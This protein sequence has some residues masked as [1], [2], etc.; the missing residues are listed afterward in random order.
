MASNEVQSI[1]WFDGSPRTLAAATYW[2][3]LSPTIHGFRGNGLNS[4]IPFINGLDY[5][6]A[7]AATPTTIGGKV[8]TDLT[9]HEGFRFA[10]EVHRVLIFSANLPDAIRGLLLDYLRT[11][12]RLEPY[13][14]QV[15]FDGSSLEA[16][17]NS[18][19]N[20]VLTGWSDGDY[21]YSYPYYVANARPSWKCLNH[22]I[23]SETVTNL[24]DHAA[25]AIDPYFDPALGENIVVLGAPT[26][27]LLFGVDLETVEEIYMDYV[28]QRQDVG[29]KVLGQA[30]PDRID[31]DADQQADV[32]TFN[33]RL[34]AGMYGVDKVGPLP[35]G[36]SG[37]SWWEAS[38]TKA[39]ADRT[40]L[41]RL[42]FQD[43]AAAT[44]KALDS[45]FGYPQHLKHRLL[46][47]R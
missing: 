45:F 10:G 6:P 26:N 13:E 9:F 24:A 35:I 37:K 30:I 44:L 38:P 33:Q 1:H 39:D 3:R 23:S 2:P 31:F 19:E 4:V 11:K 34:I 28:A 12:Y 36:L 42:G 27:D 18:V 32:D 14:A 22:G 43:W 16:G 29:F 15:I 8:G 41:S 17:Y 21:T 47:P 5:P 25:D 20:Q 40:H 7:L 46:K